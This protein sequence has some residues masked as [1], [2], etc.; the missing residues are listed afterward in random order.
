MFVTLN[1]YGKG[2]KARRLKNGSIS[3]KC[4]WCRT[5]VDVDAKILVWSK[6]EVRTVGTVACPFEECCMPYDIV[7]SNFVV[8]IPKDTWEW[9]EYD[10]LPDAKI[11]KVW[12]TRNEHRKRDLR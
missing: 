3:Y 6:N 4:P 8:A 11:F 7:H 12:R 2:I 10:G 1:C 5:R 9:P